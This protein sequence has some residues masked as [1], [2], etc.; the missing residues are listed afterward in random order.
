MA[1]A[2]IL[3]SEDNITTIHISRTKRYTI[4]GVLLFISCL[5]VTAGIS[6]ETDAKRRLGRTHFQSNHAIL[7]T[8]FSHPKGFSHRFKIFRSGFLDFNVL[9]RL[10]WADGRQYQ[11]FFFVH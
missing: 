11:N 8:P 6:I 9:I 4:H 7:G 10:D 1:A 3:F 2:I 5:A